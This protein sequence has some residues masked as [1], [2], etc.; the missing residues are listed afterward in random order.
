MLDNLQAGSLVNA[1]SWTQPSTLSY[2]GM[3]HEGER[4]WTFQT[5]LFTSLF[6]DDLSQSLMEQKSL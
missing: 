3:S 5:I 6:I 1:S 4:S 2:Q